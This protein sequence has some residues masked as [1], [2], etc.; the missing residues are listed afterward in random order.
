M[1]VILYVDKLNLHKI[2]LKIK[3]NKKYLVRLKW[4]SRKTVYMYMYK[5]IFFPPENYSQSFF[6]LNLQAMII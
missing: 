4:P 1:G 6:L 5:H 2:F 3:E